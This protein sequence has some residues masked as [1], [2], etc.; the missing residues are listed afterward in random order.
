MTDFLLINF[1]YITPYFSNVKKDMNKNKIK[2]LSFTTKWL[3]FLNESKDFFQAN[4]SWENLS[5]ADQQY[6][7]NQLLR[8]G[9]KYQIEICMYT[10]NEKHCK[11]NFFLIKKYLE[12]NWL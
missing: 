10:E 6:K 11:Y 7:N 8:A 12:E 2:T 9:R 1:H 3:F 4:E 5:A